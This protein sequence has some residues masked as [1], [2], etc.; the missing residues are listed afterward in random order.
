MW[1]Q[2]FY[3]VNAILVRGDRAL[4]DELA[5]RPDVLRIEGNPVIHNDIPEPA[6]IAET[7]GPD[8]IEWGIART[9][10]PDVWAMGFTGQGIVV[11]GQNTGVDCVH[12]AIKNQY[13]GWNGS[14]ADHDYNWHDS[15]HGSPGN[16]CGSD[17]VEPCDDHGHDPLRSRP[18]LYSNREPLSPWCS[19]DAH[20]TQA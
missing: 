16:P 18:S 19:D 12:P 9:N 8:A 5:Q 20:P 4:V 13:R 3:I 10:A 14:V 11:E 15:V 2:P 7:A 1:Y 17:S 6:Q